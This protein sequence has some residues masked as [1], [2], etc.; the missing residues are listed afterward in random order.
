MKR[1]D[2]QTYEK[3]YKN[4][5]ITWDNK[6]DAIDD[7]ETIRNIFLDIAY[8]L[9]ILADMAMERNGYIYIKDE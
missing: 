7:D 2:L 6:L 9:H 4:N 3:N 8:S 5:L 1:M